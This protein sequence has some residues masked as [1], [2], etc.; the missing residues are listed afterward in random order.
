MKSEEVGMSYIGIVASP[1]T[2][3]KIRYELKIRGLSTSKNM[4]GQYRVISEALSEDEDM[5]NATIASP[6]AYFDSNSEFN[7][8]WKLLGDVKMIL[9]E[10]RVKESDLVVLLAR[11]CV[12]HERVKR[13]AEQ[14]RMSRKFVGMA[15]NVR[16]CLEKVHQ[17]L[18]KVKTRE[19]ESAYGSPFSSSRSFETSSETRMAHQSF[20][21]RTPSVPIPSPTMG[22][23]RVE[24]AKRVQYE[25]QGTDVPA[26]QAVT[27]CNFSRQEGC[28]RR[29]N[30]EFP[31]L[32]EED[33]RPLY[34]LKKELDTENQQTRE[35]SRK[36]VNS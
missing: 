31:S 12:L 19:M 27:E 34:D 8:C 20:F 25:L 4:R 24:M 22:K 5:N 11:V 26:R 7:Q 35:K 13:N 28:D 36:R 9:D 2:L 29:A 14:E 3:E 32:S 10:D 16:L 33:L 1:W 6:V 15:E 18:R 30:Q 21:P 23:Q 17:A